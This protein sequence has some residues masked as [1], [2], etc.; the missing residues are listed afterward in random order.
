MWVDFVR[1][2]VGLEE[3][4]VSE[5]ASDEGDAYPFFTFCAP[6]LCVDFMFSKNNGEIIQVGVVGGS[7]LFRERDFSGMCFH[8]WAGDYVHS[9]PY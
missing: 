7:G 2:T 3:S 4:G 9:A 6:S 8:V 5:R 1:R